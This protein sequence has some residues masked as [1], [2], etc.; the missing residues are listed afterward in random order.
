METPPTSARRPL[1][2]RVYE[3]IADRI[4]SGSLERG[5]QLPTEREFCQEMGVSRAT[6][7]RAIAALEEEGLIQAI[8]GRGTFVTAP[9]LTSRRTR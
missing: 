6:V 8:Q 5:G 7:R 4:T 9:R 1:Y 3:E 2:V